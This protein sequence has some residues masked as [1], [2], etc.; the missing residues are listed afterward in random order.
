MKSKTNIC[1]CGQG[2]YFTVHN[3]KI[4]QLVFRRTSA[5]LSGMDCLGPEKF[6]QHSLNSSKLLHF[7]CRLHGASKGLRKC[8]LFQYVCILF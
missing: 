6:E 7:S 4:A 5:W 1:M 3:D 2:I 8:F